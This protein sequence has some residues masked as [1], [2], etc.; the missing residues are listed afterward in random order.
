AGRAGPRVCG[1]RWRWG[2]LADRLRH[3]LPRGG[4]VRRVLQRLRRMADR[5]ALA[6]CVEQQLYEVQP[7]RY[8]L[9]TAL[10]RGGDAV[11]QWRLRHAT[12]L[13]CP[14]PLWPGPAAPEEPR[15]ARGARG[16][17]AKNSE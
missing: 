5:L 1:H 16:A 6:P 12:R 4:V 11:N 14:A 3:Q 17:R 15:P 8:I 10:H 9:R 7:Q 2:W 13:S